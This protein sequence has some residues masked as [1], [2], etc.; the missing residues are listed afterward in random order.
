MSFGG[1]GSGAH[2]GQCVVRRMGSNRIVHAR[3]AYRDIPVCLLT[4]LMLKPCRTKA[5]ARLRVAMSYTIANLDAVWPPC[6]RSRHRSLHRVKDREYSVTLEL[7]VKCPEWDSNPHCRWFEHR[8]S[9]RWS[10]GALRIE[11]GGA[12]SVL[13]RYR[14]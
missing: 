10:T 5:I 12:P 6:A 8:L 1:R 11:G 13:Q 4:E 2:L 7:K 14:R 9:N 3:I